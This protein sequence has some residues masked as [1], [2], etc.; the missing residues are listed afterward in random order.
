MCVCVCV[1]VCVCLC[2]CGYCSGRAV[3][4]CFWAALLCIVSY[5]SCDRQGKGGVVLLAAVVYFMAPSL[6]HFFFLSPLLK[7]DQ[8]ASKKNVTQQWIIWVWCRSCLTLPPSDRFHVVFLAAVNVTPLFPPVSFLVRQVDNAKVL[9][10]VGAGI[11]F[12]TSMLFVCLQSA[13][14][15]RLAKTQG[16]YNVA[17]LR[18]CMTLL[19]F[20]ALVLSIL[21]SY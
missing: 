18:L 20:V 13:L 5:C 14:T 6:F 16:E 21:S 1:C 10:Y 8:E 3:V 17:H 19:A 7:E 4:T 9:H 12:P 11:A 2:V 15:Y